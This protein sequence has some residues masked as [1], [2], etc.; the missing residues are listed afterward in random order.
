M[1]TEIIYKWPD[2]REEVRY[3]RHKD[4]PEALQL[5]GLVE[6][7]R[8]KHGDAS[9]YSYRHIEGDKGMTG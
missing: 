6:E 1:T 4:S 8:A 3:R 7:L 9:P 2:G 5:V